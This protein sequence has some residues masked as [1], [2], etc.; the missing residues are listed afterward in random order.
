MSGGQLLFHF[1]TDFSS[2]SHVL[3]FPKVP[4][5]DG[6]ETFKWAEWHREAQRLARRL[7]NQ[8]TSQEDG[9]KHNRNLRNP[10]PNSRSWTSHCINHQPASPPDS[11]PP[12]TSQGRLVEQAHCWETKQQFLKNYLNQESL[13][14]FRC[15]RKVEQ[16]PTPPTTNILIR[17]FWY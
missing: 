15:K 17:E 14:S 10:G 5:C 6:L 2:N 1:Y 4:V 12:S 9:W 16:R 11:P 8:A 3:C 13:V 7:V